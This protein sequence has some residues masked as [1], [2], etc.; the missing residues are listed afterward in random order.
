[1]KKL[2]FLLFITATLAGCAAV[3]PPPQKDLT[4]FK[5][6][7]PASLLVVPVVNHSVEVTAPNYFL[8]TVTIPLAERGYYVFPV[9][10]V[11][12]VLEDDGLADADLVHNAP[13]EKLCNLFGADA[14]LYVTIN[15][16]DAKY[17]VLN[18]QVTIN[19]TYVIKDGK[20][21]ETLWEHQQKMVYAPQNQ[22]TGSAAG[23]LLSM[24]INAALTKAAPNYVPLARQANALAFYGEYVGIPPG[25]YAEAVVTGK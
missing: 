23:D 15:E 12:R 19:L 24:M 4:K 21:G 1:M 16:W 18:T 20:T 9:N 25:P 5:A 7:H 17:L 14:I 8:A 13:T 10:M 6:A 22:S 11:K 3:A 2:V